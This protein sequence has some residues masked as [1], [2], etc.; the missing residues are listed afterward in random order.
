VGHYTLY[1]AQAYGEGSY[2]SCNY[3]EGE[4]SEGVCAGASTGTGNSPS[5]GLADTG[6]A[7]AGIVSL[8]CLLVFV[9]ILV[10]VWRRRKPALQVVS[11]EQ[12]RI[13]SDDK[14]Q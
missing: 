12:E 2:S 5:G 4:T 3:S 11:A 13:R 14:L 7:I 8:A 6:L 10:R 1:F 9:A